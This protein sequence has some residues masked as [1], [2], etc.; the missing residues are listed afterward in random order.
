MKAFN[1]INTNTKARRL[2]YLLQIVK[3]IGE[4]SLAEEALL[5][6]LTSW[7][8]NNKDLLEQYVDS[9]GGVIKPS[10][11]GTAARR[12]LSVASGIELVGKIGR[13]Y[14][15]T[16]FGIVLS[17]LSSSRKTEESPFALTLKE[18]CFFLNRLFIFDSD[19][20]IPILQILREHGE[21]TL[22]LLQDN[23]RDAVMKWLEIKANS[24]PVE[25][26]SEKNELRRVEDRIKKWRKPKKYVEH[27]VPPRIHWL[28]DLRLIDWD[29][30][31]K[32]RKYVLS[33]EGERFISRIPRTPSQ[34]HIYF[35]HE[36]IENNY[37]EEFIFAFSPNLTISRFSQL[38]S[39]QQH[40]IVEGYLERSFKIF[41]TVGIKRVVALQLLYYTCVELSVTD[42]I[43]CG[44]NNIKQILNNISGSPD[45]VYYFYW[46]KEQ[47][48]G[49]ITK[50]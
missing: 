23:F 32:T 35:N 8:T 37:F 28:I 36:W 33:K 43:A 12:Y 16:K 10:I 46:S 40:E 31:K 2:G 39:A 17:V 20:L 41:I 45:S 38:P 14:K 50:R 24:I 30:Y 18:I 1:S 42:R 15:L 25:E 44:F 11:K 26:Y 47:S 19:Y 29:H 6:R 27:I 7:G 22:S 4:I 13:E 21:C 34:N 48:D 49:Y 3:E 9:T 5:A